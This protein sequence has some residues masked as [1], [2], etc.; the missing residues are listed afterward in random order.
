MPV[1]SLRSSVL[2]WPD[3]AQVTRAARSWAGAASSQHPGV[4]RI[5]YFGSYARDHAGVGSD[6]D[7][8][9]I[10]RD[11]EE[12]FVQRGAAWPV[13][14]LP[15]PADL[16]VYTQEEWDCLTAGNTRFARVLRD[17]VVWLWP[18]DAPG[19]ASPRRRSSRS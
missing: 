2:V 6:L 11:S 15:V 5:G 10:V 13:E 18:D 8:V 12:P 16:L 19:S 4:V 3:R 17:E 9:A 1:R 14:Q 7:L